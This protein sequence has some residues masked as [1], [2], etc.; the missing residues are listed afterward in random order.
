MMIKI[1]LQTK[2]MKQAAATPAIEKNTGSVHYPGAHIGPTG[3][4]LINNNGIREPFSMRDIEVRFEAL[5]MRHNPLHVSAVDTDSVGTTVIDTAVA[6]LAIGM[7]GSDK[8]IGIDT[9]NHRD[10]MTVVIST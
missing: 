7:M 8:D 6:A 4:F 5:D 2:S 9:C 3:I 10:I 1:F